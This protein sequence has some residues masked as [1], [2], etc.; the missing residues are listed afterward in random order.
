M[1]QALRRSAAPA[2]KLGI[3]QLSDRDFDRLAALIGTHAGIKLPR[4]KRLMVEGRLRKRVRY[5]G[6]R[7]LPEYCAF[8]FEGG[9]LEREFVH[10]VDAVTTNKTDFFREP[11]HFG[12]LEKVIVPTLLRAPRA[13]G[14]P[15]LK[16][17]SAASSNG[18]EAYTIAMVLADCSGRLGDFQYAVLGTDI[19]TEV[20]GHAARAVY[21]E[22][23]VRP[24]PAHMQKLYLMRGRRS[25][26]SEEVR[27]VPELRRLVRFSQLNLMDASYPFDRDVDV[28]FLRNV[29]I[30]FDKATQQAVV[31][32]LLGHLRP[33]GYLILGHS[34]SMIGTAL[35][36]RQL[37]PAIFQH[38]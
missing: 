4:T 3:D 23:M 16:I 25:G 5:L 34:E 28:I 31:K 32:R 1:T 37:A 22:E 19:S 30:Y 18:A 9:G 7:S 21:P 11:E 33:G 13:A 38:I 29:L 2:E 12:F 14:K 17:W 35:A 24:V 6:H 8:L 36:L 10:L 15:L 20:L 27:I 26:R